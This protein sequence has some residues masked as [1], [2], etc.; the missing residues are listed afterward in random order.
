MKNIFIL[1]VVLFAAQV[2]ASGQFSSSY[3]RVESVNLSI[4]NNGQVLTKT[5]ANTGKWIGQQDFKTFYGMLWIPEK[6]VLFVSGILSGSNTPALVKISSIGG[7]GQNMF[8]LTPDGGSV[9]GYNYR[10]GSQS[11]TAKEMNYDNDTLFIDNGTGVVYKI[12]NVGGTGYNM[13][14]LDNNACRSLSGY[15]YFLGCS[16]Y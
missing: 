11:I 12:R 2:Y 16:Y 4:S 6:N 8:A 5:D 7:S 13:F 3:L 9:S 15:N 1:L 10:L 14:A